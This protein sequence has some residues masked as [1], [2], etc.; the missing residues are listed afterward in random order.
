MLKL[1][2]KVKIKKE[3]KQFIFEKLKGLNI[4]FN[5]EK[6]YT[7]SGFCGEACRFSEFPYEIIFHKLLLEKVSQ[8]ELF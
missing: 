7:I 8:L 2:D 1:G 3:Y 5:V 4:Y 6:I